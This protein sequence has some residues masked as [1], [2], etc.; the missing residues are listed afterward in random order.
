MT[1]MEFLYSKRS[2][3]SGP[4][5]VYLIGDQ[6][7]E[8]KFWVETWTDILAEIFPPGSAQVNLELEDSRECE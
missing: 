2:V 5:L 4:P 8:G 3:L 1:D 7:R 6:K